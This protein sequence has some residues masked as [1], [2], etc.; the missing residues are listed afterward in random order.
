MRMAP[1][2]QVSDEWVG[3]WRVPRVATYRKRLYEAH[4]SPQANTL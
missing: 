1:P 4:L 2:E 3:P